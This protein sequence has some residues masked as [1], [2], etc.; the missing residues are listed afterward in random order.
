MDHSTPEG[1]SFPLLGEP[2]PG[3]ARGA[4]HGWG[5]DLWGCGLCPLSG[6]SARASVLSVLPLFSLL[7]LVGLI[8]YSVPPLGGHYFYM[9]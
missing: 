3:H 4:V 8:I 6:K 1:L 9:E 5:G 7:L 2:H